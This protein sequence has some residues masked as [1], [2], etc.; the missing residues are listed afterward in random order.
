MRS[1][2]MG[3]DLN[4]WVRVAQPENVR[5]LGRLG[6]AAVIVF[7]LSLDLSSSVLRWRAGKRAGGVRRGQSMLERPVRGSMLGIRGAAKIP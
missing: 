1:D 3:R 4:E 6:R 5:R 7:S 2:G